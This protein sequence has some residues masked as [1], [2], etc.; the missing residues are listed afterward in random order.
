MKSL[1]KRV[2]K[3]CEDMPNATR[4]RAILDAIRADD[5]GLRNNLLE[6]TPKRSYK[7]RD[8]QVVDSIEAAHILSLRFDRTFYHLLACLIAC[9]SV[10]VVGEKPA[11]ETETA[12]ENMDNQLCA[13]VSGAKI[14][15]GRIGLELGQLL[16]F[17]LALD[18]EFE[19]LDWPM[20]TLPK[21]NMERANEVAD[22]FQELWGNYGN[23]I[24]GFGK[25]A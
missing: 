11:E 13:L 8:A 7:A 20:D 21:E 4:T 2:T 1:D 6:A 25:V 9:D 18:S 22:A 3:L 23:S 15:G 24:D 10:G 12:R 17:S 16:A 19:G 5:K 14:F